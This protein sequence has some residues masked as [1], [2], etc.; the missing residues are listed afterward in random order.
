MDDVSRHPN[1]KWPLQGWG[2]MGQSFSE[3]LSGVIRIYRQ[4]GEE[5][6]AQASERE[7][8]QIRRD[9]VGRGSMIRCV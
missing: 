2:Q 8:G 9:L 7:I 3:L 4:G 1:L 5:G 6:N